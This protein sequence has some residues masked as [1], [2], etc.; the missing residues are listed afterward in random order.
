MVIMLLLLSILIAAAA[1]AYYDDNDDD[2][3]DRA[4]YT[5]FLIAVTYPTVRRFHDPGL[6]GKRLADNPCN[7]CCNQ[8]EA[9]LFGVCSAS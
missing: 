3:G 4:H 8:K 9:L 7:Y 2:E 6:W 1:A 5:F